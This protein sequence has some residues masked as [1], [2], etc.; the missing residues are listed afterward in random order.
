MASVNA[1]P[2]HRDIDLPDCSYPPLVEGQICLGLTARE[3]REIYEHCK[4]VVKAHRV[5]FPPRKRE[6]YGERLENSAVLVLPLEEQFPV[7]KR[8]KENWGAK[9]VLRKASSAVSM[10]EGQQSRRH[11][12]ARRSVAR[13]PAITTNVPAAGLRTTAIMSVGSVV[14]DASSSTRSNDPAYAPAN[15]NGEG[16]EPKRYPRM[17]TNMVITRKNN[18]GYLGRGDNEIDMGAN[19][20]NVGAGSSK[21]QIDTAMEAKAEAEAEDTGRLGRAPFMQPGYC[22]LT[23][24]SLPMITRKYAYID[25]SDACAALFEA[26]KSWLVSESGRL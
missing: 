3:L 25:D 24:W 2:A 21:R 11:S 26:S 6:R 1:M 15:P 20:N 16:A 10:M 4:I 13:L 5:S 22:S 9:W 7:L 23:N 18:F 17:R 19:A 12:E 8:C 14:S